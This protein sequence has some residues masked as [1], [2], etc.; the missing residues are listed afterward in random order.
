MSCTATTDF[1]LCRATTVGSV[2]IWSSG[3]VV[4][5]MGSPFIYRV[6]VFTELMD[7]PAQEDDISS[8]N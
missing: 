3:I 5:I 4:R 6:S 8:E 7:A 1:T 2:K